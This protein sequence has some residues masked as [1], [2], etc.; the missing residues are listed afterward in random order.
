[1]AQQL[2]VNG[3]YES[4]TSQNSNR[5]CVNFLPIIEPEGSQSTYMLE[6]PSG[7]TGPLTGGLYSGM[8]GGT[9]TSQVYDFE[10][11]GIDANTV[12]CHRNHI[13]RTDGASFSAFQ[14]PNFGGSIP[15]MY[16]ARFA[17]SSDTLVSVSDGITGGL[18]SCGASFDKSLTATTIDLETIFTQTPCGIRDVAFLGGRFIWMNGDGGG[19][20]SFRCYYSGIGGTAPVITNFFQPD[21]DTTEF[22]GLQVLNGSLWLFDRRRAYLFTLS[23]STT[24]PFQWQ[25]SATIE[26]G[27][28]SPH[29]KAE[30]LGALFL[31]GLRNTG[32]YKAMVMS[33]ASMTPIGTPAIDAAIDA[34]IKAGGFASVYAMQ[35][36]GREFC[37]FNTGLRTFVYSIQDKRWSERESGTG[38]NF[39]GIGFVGRDNNVVIGKNMTTADNTVIDIG[40]LDEAIGTEFGVEVERYIDTAPFNANGK[41]LRVSEVEPVCIVDGSS[42]YSINASMSLDA[43]ETF[44]AERSINVSGSNRTRFLNWGIISQT[45][46][47]R[48]KFSSPFPTKIIKILA[49]ITPGGRE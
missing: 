45:F 30:I 2:P 43:S 7:I 18:A 37:V 19:A 26:G 35:D 28:N 25:R 46:T 36:K 4:T 16:R 49:R 47:M 34:D 31:I 15:Y 23:G 29:S 41:S 24:T 44:G 32:Q 40:V 38:D 33:G 21:M 39:V 11:N 22:T 42:D 10:N 14:I 13:L 1:M 3:F 12:F 27:L 8:T 6:C 17:S 9:I 48:F 20:N 5:R